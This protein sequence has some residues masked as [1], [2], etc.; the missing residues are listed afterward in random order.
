LGIGDADLLTGV[1]IVQ[2][3]LKSGSPLSHTPTAHIH[4]ATLALPSHALTAHTHPAHLTLRPHILT[5]H[6]HWAHLTL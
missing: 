1:W 3:P 2:K 4:S 5:A 6:T